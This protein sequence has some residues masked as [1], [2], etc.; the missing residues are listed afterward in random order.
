MAVV[1]ILLSSLGVQV[2]QPVLNYIQSPEILY[3][4]TDNN[5]T[6]FGATSYYNVTTPDSS[7]SHV[8]VSFLNGFNMVAKLAEY[9]LGA[10]SISPVCL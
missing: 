5:A 10:N 2:F 7:G 8:Q 9:S 1:L 4:K 3:L 6:V